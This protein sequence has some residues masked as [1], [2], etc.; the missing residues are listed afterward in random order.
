MFE[1]RAGP[2]YSLDVCQEAERLP[3]R[4]A[5]VKMTT[6]LRSELVELVGT[7]EIAEML[8]LSRQRVHQLTSKPD[9]P[10]PLAVLAAGVIWRREDV[11]EWGRRTGRLPSGEG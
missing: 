10:Q 8:G 2:F 9:F 6:T 5:I 11:E 4:L 1:H 3:E 7:A